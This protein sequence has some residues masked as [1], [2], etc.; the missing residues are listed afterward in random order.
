MQ[1]SGHHI[2]ITGGTSGIGAA[3]AAAFFKHGNDVGI[4]GRRTARLK[5]MQ[6]RLP[7]L[8]ALACDLSVDTGRRALFEWAQKEMPLLN[9]L[10]NN[11]GIQRDIDFTHGLDDYLSGENEIQVNLQSP[12]ELTG[13]FAPFI[14]KNKNPA[15]I[16]VS[17]GLGFVPAAAMPVYCA[18]KAGMH[19]FTLAIRHQLQAV[20]IRVYEI[21]P[22]A[23]DTELNPQGRAKRGGFKANLTPEQL[24]EGVMKGLADDLPEIG[25]GAS[26]K[27][28]TASRRE[29]DES[30]KAMNAG[31]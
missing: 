9:I 21:V 6:T 30:F 23:V 8:K 15:I 31:W 7:G 3:L 17:S 10:V 24:V 14:R 19:A 13:L 26:A 20:G 1:L 12:I 16:N 28:I 11:A 18:T 2:L 27:F 4:C 25:Y 29:L 5:E 22:P